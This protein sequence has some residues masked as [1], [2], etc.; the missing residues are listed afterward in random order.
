MSSGPLK[1][2]IRFGPLY[3]GCSRCRC[4]KKLRIGEV[5]RLR[6]A[7]NRIGTRLRSN[8]WVAR[9]IFRPWLPSEI[10]SS[11]CIGQQLARLDILEASLQLLVGCPWNHSAPRGLNCSIAVRLCGGRILGRLDDDCLGLKSSKL[12]TVAI[13]YQS[14][15]LGKA[16]FTTRL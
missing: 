9:S 3:V 12:A 4:A 10:R 5:P 13:S 8:E 11:G 7:D 6:W 15:R 16:M 1:N 14:H 2:V